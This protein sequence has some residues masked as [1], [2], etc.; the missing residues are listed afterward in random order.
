MRYYG[1]NENLQTGEVMPVAGPTSGSLVDYELIVGARG[2]IGR[3]V[4]LGG[5][6][7][8]SHH[9]WERDMTQI[10]GGILPSAISF[11]ALSSL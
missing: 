3:N 10:I 9:S 4:L 5:F 11:P 1:G 2:H 8:V 6:A 7:G